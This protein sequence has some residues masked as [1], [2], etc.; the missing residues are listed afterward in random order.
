V[1]HLALVPDYLDEAVYLG[2]LFIVG[3]IA[4]VYVGARLWFTRDLVAWIIG[5]AA[6]ACMFVGL[7]LSRT[8][9][10]PS[11][12]ETEWEASGV[13]TL[14]LEAAYLV[15]MG[16]WMSSRRRRSRAVQEALPAVPEPI[17]DALISAP[18]A[19]PGPRRRGAVGDGRSAPG[20]LRGS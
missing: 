13:V 17:G 9:G 1:I 15:A 11:F 5:G 8:V 6:A 10:L 19:P 3:G 7:I 2:V 18:S 12:H 4:L 16:W 14:V 20:S